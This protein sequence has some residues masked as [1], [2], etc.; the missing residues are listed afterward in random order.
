MI[1][2]LGISNI[3]TG[4]TTDYTFYSQVDI[5]QGQTLVIFISAHGI[6]L[7]PTAPIDWQFVHS[8]ENST[9]GLFCYYFQPT[10]T[11]TNPHWTIGG[12]SPDFNTG[13]CVFLSGVTLVKS[14]VIN[15]NISVVNTSGN[16][17][18]HGFTTIVNNTAI[19]QSVSIL[20]I[21]PDIPPYVVSDS[22]SSTPSLPWIEGYGGNDQS[23]K[24]H[25]TYQVSHGCAIWDICQKGT[26]T[27][28]TYNLSS[29]FDNLTIDV[30]LS[31]A[32]AS[33]PNTVLNLLKSF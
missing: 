28:F 18:T 14:N 22:W 20:R 9:G 2:Y 29:N 16:V 27:E 13:Y 21:G 11:I 24:T 7:Q 19:I 32:G 33:K 12:L 3:C 1:S 23:I 10:G 26:Y 8:V 4:S 17:G 30:A 5:Y 15:T 6:G 31:P 25:N